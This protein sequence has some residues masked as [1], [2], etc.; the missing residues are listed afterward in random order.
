MDH[1]LLLIYATIAMALIFDFING[2]HD[3][4]NSIATIVSTRVLKPQ[5]AVAWAAFFN[6]AA[7]LI[8]GT[9]V[10]TTIAKDVVVQEILQGIEGIA[11]AALGGRLSG[12]LAAVGLVDHRVPVIPEWE[13]EPRR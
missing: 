13:G 12:L 7:F 10:A 6:F 5:Y 2:F 11:F 4:A 8:F 9:A 3:A 1:T